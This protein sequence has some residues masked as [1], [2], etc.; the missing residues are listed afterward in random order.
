VLLV[1]L[2]TAGR[3]TAQ[4]KPASATRAAPGVQ[5]PTASI[6]GTIVNSLNQPVSDAGITVTNSEQGLERK[7]RTNDEGYFYIPFLPP[8]NYTLLI[9]MGG[10]AT[11]RVSELVLESS[12]N[13]VV[14]L[15]LQP[16]G[17]KEVIDVSAPQGSI[18]PSS[19]TIRY[20][21]PASQI[22]TL[23]MIATAAG[24]TI[25]DS[26]PVFLPGVLPAEYVGIRGEGLVVNGARPLSNSFSIE[27]GDNNDYEQNRAASPFPNPDALQEVTIETSNFKADVGGAAGAVVDAT[28][29]PGTNHFHGNLRYF[30][31]DE[32]LGARS[33]FDRERFPFITNSFGGQ[34]GG[35]LRIPGI[36]DGSSRTH[37]FFDAESNNVGQSNDFIQSTLSSAYRAGDFSGLPHFD[38]MHPSFPH[39]P[40][41]PATGSPFPGGIIPP[42]R[43]DP[44]SR[45]YLDNLIAL[46]DYGAGETISRAAWASRNIQYTTRIDQVLSGADQLTGVLFVDS[47]DYV[48][49]SSQGRLISASD[50]LSHSS[51]LIVHETHN[52]SSVA[53]NQLTGTFTRFVEAT[54][55][56]SPTAARVPPSQAGFTGVHDQDPALAGLPSVTI[57]SAD[58]FI[59]AGGVSSSQNAKTTFAIK[60]DFAW[61]VSSHTV[62]AGGGARSFTS[63]RSNSYVSEYPYG[64]VSTNGAFTFDD[65]NPN[66][67]GNAIADFLLG[68]PSQ[69]VQSSGL[70]Q[71]P[72]QRSYSAYV[73]DD[74][75]LRPDLTL[76]VGVRYE[77]TPPFI[78][79]LN[80][81]V[82]FRPGAHSSTFPN[83]PEG[84]LFP[85]DPDPIL[86]RV[87]RAG[88][89]ASLVDFAPRFGVAFS[90]QSGG[91]TRKL[92]GSGKSAI[93][94]GFGMFYSP[95]YG[96]DFSKFTSL[97]PFSNVV[98]VDVGK[99]GSFANPFGTQPNPFPIAPR[100]VPLS[101]G[102]SIHTF[103]PRFRPAYT[104]QYNV[105]IQRELRG[106]L[107]L[108]LSYIGSNSFRLDRE[109]ELNPYNGPLPWFG[110]WGRRYNALGNVDVQTS[111]GRSHYDSLQ[112]RL[113]HR[114][115]GGLMFDV[116][117][118]LSKSLDN[119]SGP[120]YYTTGNSSQFDVAGASYPYSWA[121]SEFDRRQNFV[122]FYSYDFPEVAKGGLLGVLLNRWQIGGITQLRSGTPLDLVALTANLRPDF[123]GRFRRFDPRQ[124]RTFIVDGTAVTSNFLFDPNAFAYP[125]V[126]S[127]NLGRNVFDGPGLNLT[128]L[129]VVKRNY[130]HESQQIEL[131]ADITNLFNHANFST[132]GTLAGSLGFGQ[133]TSARAGRSVQLSIKYKF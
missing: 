13:S 106:S 97:A 103:D 99:D 4:V 41:D 88:Y 74:W 98:S 49:S 29:R 1:I 119:A 55:G 64:P 28:V 58:S 56:E 102:A 115:R 15:T 121:R 60:D 38:P 66:G 69:Y 112:A 101:L 86:G 45:Y 89:R 128:S 114:F 22:D 127:G 83:A 107:L 72:R 85:S 50:Q 36:Y 108:E 33:F 61:V 87:P 94:A 52:F 6:S 81:V 9:E 3:A 105:T 132:L 122:A 109:I 65:N 42:G 73:M 2:V 25:L 30:F 68:L 57:Q 26:L 77:L 19:A 124:V 80:Q 91:L 84:M 21:I 24:R 12:V 78:D 90:P 118:V 70:V 51:N 44:I 96:Y 120:S 32:S 8:G 93:R 16:K 95:T 39:R 62:K 126:P 79:A 37:F 110:F 82:V 125:S 133:V 35:P 53:V 59:G 111:D 129:S 43:I 116:S 23:P 71:R 67:T 130:I 17:I 48:S 92:L 75:R 47:N 7:T 104:Y 131:R 46:P 31:F 113:S 54:A 123:V 20:T 100:D 34:I 5:G 10:F 14:S 63:N 27:G 18:D 40:I 11:I 117:Y 76:N